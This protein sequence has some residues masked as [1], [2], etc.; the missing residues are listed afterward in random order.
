MMSCVGH[1]PN[2]ALINKL[3]SASLSII[4][5]VLTELSNLLDADLV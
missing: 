2:F 3:N 1:S 5:L 4:N